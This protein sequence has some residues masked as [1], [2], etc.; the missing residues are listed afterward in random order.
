MDAAYLHLVVNHF[1]IVL[2]LAGTLAALVAL[3]VQ[4]RG[5]WVY[6]TASITLA[7]LTVYPVMLTGHG[8]EEIVERRWYASREAIRAHE[9]AAELATW[10]TLGA[11]VVAAYGWFRAA[12]PR[13][14]EDRFPGSLQLL[15][16]IAGLAA[17]ASLGY[18]SW[19][20]GFI[21]HKA[22]SP[23]GTVP[24]VEAQPPGPPP[25]P[26]VIP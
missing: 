20:S 25:A 17:S 12:R 10:I 4:K 22:A 3:G 18:A 16:T 14:R 15:V 8:A 11:G 6:A 26:S 21:V 7:A 19:Q 13:H 1:P 5:G 24:G 23:P 9:E 2:C